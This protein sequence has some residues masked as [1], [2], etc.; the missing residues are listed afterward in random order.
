[1]DDVWWVEVGCSES[2]P[3]LQSA[4]RG[5]QNGWLSGGA[6]GSPHTFRPSHSPL[7]SPT[8]HYNRRCRMCGGA[9]HIA[10]VYVIGQLLSPCPPSS[11][12]L[13]RLALLLPS[14][15]ETT[16]PDVCAHCFIA[17]LVLSSPYDRVCITRRCGPRSREPCQCHRR[18]HLLTAAPLPLGRRVASQ[19]APR[20]TAVPPA[21]ATTG[22][23]GLPAHLWR[24]GWSDPRRWLHL[25]P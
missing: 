23:L 19:V 14:P 13:S 15:A 17:P 10:H 12:A 9:T 3:K 1:M 16:R 8:V 21:P 18:L 5:V 24:R 4:A 7:P 6:R 2:L 11:T 22:V 20:E 25:R